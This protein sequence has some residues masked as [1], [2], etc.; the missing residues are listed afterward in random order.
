M[1]LPDVR[2]K[3]N[4]MTLTDQR[5]RYALVQATGKEERQRISRNMHIS[6]SL[7]RVAAKAIFKQYGWPAISAIGKDGQNNFW[8]MIQHADDDLPFQ[9]A[10]LS[11]MRKL[12]ATGEVNLENYAFLFDR[13]RCNLNYKQ[14]YGTQ[15]N[16]ASNGKATGFR[17]IDH[18]EAVDRRRAAIGLLPLRLYALTYG[19]DYTYM[20]T[21]EA[22]RRD[23]A[24]RQGL[25][26]L[27]TDAGS[28]YRN[29]DFQQM[30]DCYDKA[31]MILSGM[32]NAENYQAAI[33]FARVATQN[34]DD[35][36][37]SMALD[38]LNLLY[39]RHALDK[40]KLKMQ[41]AFRILYKNP[42]WMS[43]YGDL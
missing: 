23:S 32:S 24:E 11:A 17:R 40:N 31:S 5:L 29:K 25:R 15:V 6:D 27:I 21:E 35:R 13:V 1:A 2:K 3:I 4:R 10:A 43:I 41:P 12:K 9:Q 37:S 42:R 39:L 26:D 20:T 18:E 34:K 8:L 28:L 16:W 19:F 30:Y 38:F 36:F 33:L 7:N 14:W 22:N